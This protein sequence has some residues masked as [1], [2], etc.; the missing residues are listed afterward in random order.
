MIQNFGTFTYH[1]AQRDR[2]KSG[3][4][5]KTWAQC[6]PQIFDEDDLRIVPN[7]APAGYHFYEWLS[8]VLL[9]ESFGYLSLVEKYCFKNHAHKREILLKLM[10]LDLSEKMSKIPGSAQTPDLLVYALDYSDWFFC[11]VK[12]PRDRLRTVQEQYFAE[13]ESTFGKPV[14]LIKF[15]D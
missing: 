2:F 13:L 9:Y 4:L 12:G 15:R 11:E 5:W 10:P 7:Q 1:H 8:A 6:Y 14:R 3:G